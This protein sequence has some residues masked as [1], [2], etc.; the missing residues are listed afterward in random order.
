[1][2]RSVCAIVLGLGVALAVVGSAHAD[3]ILRLTAEEWQCL[4]KRIPG[5]LQETLDPVFASVYG[6]GITTSTDYAAKSAFARIDPAS[7]APEQQDIEV[8]R[9]SFSLRRS[10]MRCLEKKIPD[11]IA[12]ASGLIS[13]DLAACRLEGGQ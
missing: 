12:T 9:I 5:Y 2:K 6:C 11:L 10:E 4:Q 7:P 8:K 3:P 13:F 1:M